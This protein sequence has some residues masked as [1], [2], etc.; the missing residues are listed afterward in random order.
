[1]SHRL[2][3]DFPG[4]KVEVEAPGLLI[5]RNVT[6]GLS[7]SLDGEPH[8]YSVVLCQDSDAGGESLASGVGKT[9]AQAAYAKGWMQAVAAGIG[10][11]FHPDTP[12]SAYEPP[13]EAGLADH[14]D[15]MIGFCHDHL[16]DPYAV[17]MDA[18]REHG[19]LSDGP[20]A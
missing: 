11:G 3:E 18:W 8:R 16:E 12:A 1:M 20:A 2:T 13:L 19:L 4:S 14:Y 17:A 6:C 7:I 15:A 9:E 10:L 5:L